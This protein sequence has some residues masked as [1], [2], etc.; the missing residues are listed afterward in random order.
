MGTARGAKPRPEILRVSSEDPESSPRPNSSRCRQSGKA[1][2]PFGSSG[3]GAVT[4]FHHKAEPVVPREGWQRLSPTAEARGMGVGFPRSCETPPGL[5]ARGCAN[6]G[7]FNEPAFPPERRSAPLA[8]PRWCGISPAA[9]RGAGAVA[10]P[11]PGNAT[12][13]WGQCGAG[14]RG[15]AVVHTSV[16]Q[17]RSSGS[18]RSFNQP[19]ATRAPT[20]GG[21]VEQGGDSMWQP[22]VRR[23]GESGVGASA[24]VPSVDGRRSLTR[25]GRGRSPPRD[26][27]R[28]GEPEQCRAGPLPQGC[29]AGAG[30]IRSRLHNGV[31]SAV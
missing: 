3:P 2:C 14:P 7:L 24:T 5:W 12:P 16:G 25:V 23:R 26:H 13:L 10:T 22:C 30:G 31:S 4:A 19:V 1:Q 28:G 15:R 8:R 9:R 6:T 11:R 20:G 27:G 17:E 29:P 21:V 18:I